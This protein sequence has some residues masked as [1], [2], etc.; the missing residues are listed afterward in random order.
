MNETVTLFVNEA[1]N[2]YAF[3]DPLTGVNVLPLATTLS[4]T[5][6]VIDLDS[7]LAKEIINTVEDKLLNKFAVKSLARGEPGYTRIYEG[8][9]EQRDRSYHQGISWQWLNQLYYDALKN[10]T[11]EQP[12][13]NKKLEE[14]IKGITKMYSKEIYIKPGMQGVSELTDSIFPFY[15][16]G[17]PFQAWS[18]AA[19]TRIVTG[20]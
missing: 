9:P 13:M 12:E 8:G 16:K 14:Y 5:F 7:R 6:P 15:A 1:R 17:A 19:I 4:T 3:S 2:L 11:K 20:N 10:V 18:I